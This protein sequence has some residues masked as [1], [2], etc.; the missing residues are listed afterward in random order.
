MRHR[1]LI[2]IGILAI[3]LAAC[4]DSDAPPTAPDPPAAPDDPGIVTDLTDPAAVV[5]AYGEAIAARDLAAYTALLERVP[6]TRDMPPPLPTPPPGFRFYPL[7]ADLAAFP[8]MN[9]SNHW[10]AATE[11]TLVGRMF[12]P[13]YVPAPGAAK[14]LE[15]AGSTLTIVTQAPWGPGLQ[16]VAVNATLT[17]LTGPDQGYSTQT[18]LL[19][20]LAEQPAGFLRIREITEMSMWGRDGTPEG[21]LAATW[22]R[23]K[24][25]YH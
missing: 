23:I 3:S 21:P 19:F 2:P 16:S 18:R 12:D 5:A 13:A 9:G 22:G 11:L 10:D 24:A 15:A 6:G 17:L 8:W 25:Q 1:L 7:H 4:A 20:V 14:S